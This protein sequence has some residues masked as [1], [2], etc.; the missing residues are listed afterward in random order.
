[1][2]M[3]IDGK[4]I[5]EDISLRS[6]QR[7]NRLP[8]RPLLVDVVVGNDPASMSYVSIKQRTS[9]KYGLDF[10]A[11]YLPEDASTQDIISAITEQSERDNLTGLLV[12]LP[13]PPN[14][15]RDAVLDA[16][17]KRVDVDLLSSESKND[18]YDNQVSLIPPTAGA[19]MAILDYLGEDWQDKKFLVLGQGELVGRPV[20]HLLRDRGLQVSV[21]DEFTD[22]RAVLLMTSDVIISGVGKPRLVTGDMIKSGTIIID[23]GTSESD[24]ALSG[25]MDF[26]SVSAKAKYITPVPGGVG[27]VTVAKLIENVVIKAEGKS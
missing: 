23:A 3:I 11:V 19:V 10:E 15:D 26:E 14:V 12:Q 5:A 24:G 27:P 17:P 2:K 7:I 16:I 18:F 22:D 13:L 8:Y 6:Q 25:D 21:A 4:K 20:A 1:M 9:L